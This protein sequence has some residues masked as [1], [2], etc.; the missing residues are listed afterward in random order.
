[1]HAH[2]VLGIRVGAYSRKFHERMEQ[3]TAEKADNTAIPPSICAILQSAMAEQA[4]L[5]Y[6]EVVMQSAAEKR[7][8]QSH[9][10]PHVAV[11]PAEAKASDQ[12]EKK[13]IAKTKAPKDNSGQ[14]PQQQAQSEKTV[15]APDAANSHGAN[16]ESPGEKNAN[17]RVAPPNLDPKKKDEVE[18]EPQAPAAEALAAASGAEPSGDASRP[19]QPEEKLKKKESTAKAAAAP[20]PRPTQLPKKENRKKQAKQP[21]ER[22]KRHDLNRSEAGSIAKPTDR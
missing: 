7:A 8:E 22:E 4:E 20:K 17:M 19:P 18:L 16:N 12:T 21:K 1:M 13:Q 3:A 15:I 11:V 9:A 10:A 2:D 5:Q 14:T 6:S